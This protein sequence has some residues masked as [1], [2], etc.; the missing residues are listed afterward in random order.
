MEYHNGYIVPGHVANIVDDG[1]S[2]MLYLLLNLLIL[3]DRSDVHNIMIILTD[4]IPTREIN[5][6]APEINKARQA[7]I[8]IFAIGIGPEVYE[9]EFFTTVG[10]MA[11]RMFFVDE[12][13]ALGNNVDI[14]LRSA[15]PTD[16][17]KPMFPPLR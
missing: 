4:G 7:G 14:V 13:M 15:C 5:E 11:D 10:S 3:G 16:Q 1:S 6:T 8:E 17:G 2:S 12:F 9:T